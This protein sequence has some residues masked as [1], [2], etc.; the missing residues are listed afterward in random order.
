MTRPNTS[1]TSLKGKQAEDI[2]C[3]W[4]ESKGYTI[5]SRNYTCRSGEIDIIAQDNDVIVFIEVRSLSKRSPDEALSSIHH[6][7]QQRLQK[8]AQHYLAFQAQ[9]LLDP[10]VRFDFLGVSFDKNGDVTCHLLQAAL[11]PF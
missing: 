4:L 9:H 7:K 1:Q 3:T 10:G 2:A 6:K 11:S 8:A 5:L